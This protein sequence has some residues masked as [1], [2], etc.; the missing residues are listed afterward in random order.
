M[1]AHIMED[2]TGQDITQEALK[3]KK[4]DKLAAYLQGQEAKRCQAPPLPFTKSLLWATSLLLIMYFQMVEMKQVGQYDAFADL[5]DAS[6]VFAFINILLTV[7]QFFSLSLQTHFMFAFY[8]CF[9]NAVIG[10]IFESFKMG[11]VVDE[12]KFTNLHKNVLR[13]GPVL[14]TLPIINLLL[15]ARRK[16]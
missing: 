7:P 1:D 4:A 13:S 11:Y 6:M 5:K 14:I 9:G 16:D 3:Q 10:V 2:H 8:A 12:A 15:F